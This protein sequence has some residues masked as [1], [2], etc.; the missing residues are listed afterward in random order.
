PGDG[1]R[2]R[3]LVPETADPIVPERDAG[4]QELDGH[5]RSRLAVVRDVQIARWPRG[6][7]PRYLIPSLDRLTDH[8]AG[9]PGP[10]LA[11]PRPSR[12]RNCRPICPLTAG[13]CTHTVR[14]HS[15]AGAV[16]KRG[17]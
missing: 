3:Q 16:R 5:L 12:W 10:T 6:K 7:P 9:P 4:G 8:L 2:D 14:L 11:R 15:R 17:G 1:A 13:I